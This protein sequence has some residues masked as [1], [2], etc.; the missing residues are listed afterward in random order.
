[1]SEKTNAVASAAAVSRRRFLAT[2]GA[3]AL[4]GITGSSLLAPDEAEA[5]KKKRSKKRNHGRR[6][7]K[8]ARRKKPSSRK[9][10]G[11]RVSKVA[12]RKKSFFKRRR[13]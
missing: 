7:S 6:V 10:H 5:G 4:V 3:L 13:K 8:V 11:R 12:R 1:M 2:L 9:N